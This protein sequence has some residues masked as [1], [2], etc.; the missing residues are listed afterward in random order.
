[1]SKPFKATSIVISLLLPLFLVQCYENRD[2]DQIPKDAPKEVVEFF[3]EFFNYAH[4]HRA[5][6]EW[7]QLKV[8]YV[9][10][11]TGYR[12]TYIDWGGLGKDKI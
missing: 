12:T 6:I 10:E 3:H 9:D 8:E 2:F 11:I 4:Q 7:K 1:M 5:N